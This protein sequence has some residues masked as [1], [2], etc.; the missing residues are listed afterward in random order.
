LI[1]FI[2][3]DIEL[4]DLRGVNQGPRQL[5]FT[6]FELYVLHVLFKLIFRPDLIVVL[7]PYKKLMQ[8]NFAF[9][10]MNRYRLDRSNQ[11]DLYESLP[12]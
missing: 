11:A 7:R 10:F 9:R 12:A 2:I 6:R 1:V 8:W 4:L 3:F 5:L